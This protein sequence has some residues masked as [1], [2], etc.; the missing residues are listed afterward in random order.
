MLACT[1]AYAY[2]YT[3]IQKMCGCAYVCVL[4]FV[5]L[6]AHVNQRKIL[7]FGEN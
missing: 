3:C 7:A 5:I 1:H 6:C 4:L 2:M